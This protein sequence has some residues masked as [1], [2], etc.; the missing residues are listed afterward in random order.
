MFWKIL[1]LFLN[2]LGQLGNWIIR[3][4]RYFCSRI[5]VR[6]PFLVWVGS[7]SSGVGNVHHCFFWVPY[8]MRNV[9]ENF[10]ICSQPDRPVGD[11][12]QPVHEG[13]FFQGYQLRHLSLFRSFF[14]H[15][16]LEL[17]VFA[18]FGFLTL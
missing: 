13:F 8:S 1:G 2:R 11:L 5:A 7:H 3:F 10:G 18:P 17:Y 14:I 16:K 9:L 15:P 6:A 12:D 4:I